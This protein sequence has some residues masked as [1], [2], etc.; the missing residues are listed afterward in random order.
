MLKPHIGILAISC[1]IDVMCLCRCGLYT[2]VCWFMADCFEGGGRL[3]QQL[4]HLNYLHYK[5]LNPEF[6]K[7]TLK[8]VYISY[9]K[10]GVWAYNSLGISKVTMAIIHTS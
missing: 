10:C 7:Q 3:K 5:R 2:D 4:V 1:S 6:D 9:L 8:T